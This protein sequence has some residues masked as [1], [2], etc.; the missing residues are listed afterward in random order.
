MSYGLALGH[1]APG[2]FGHTGDYD[3]YGCHGCQWAY[4]SSP[5]T[6]A[7]TSTS[8]V[9]AAASARDGKPPSS[10]PSAG[11]KDESSKGSCLSK[12]PGHGS[13][14]RPP[15]RDA[16][17]SA[18][19][20]APLEPRRFPVRAVASSSWAP[21]RGCSAR[22]RLTAPPSPRCPEAPTPPWMAEPPRPGSAPMSSP[23]F[24]SVTAFTTAAGRY[25][26]HPDVR[27]ADSPRRRS[28]QESHWA[29]LSARDAAGCQASSQCI[30]A[31]YKQHK[32]TLRNLRRCDDT[33][34]L[35]ALHAA[36][37]PRPRRVEFDLQ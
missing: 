6:T 30:E 21:R 15:W 20:P 12:T 11:R 2:G 22:S 25:S 28:R 32:A 10:A 17:A 26:P 29:P 1:P 8:E 16:L 7:R 35:G 4:D 36:A 19:P 5:P 27:W 34:R 24:D 23:D 14:K 3:Q 9:S 33:R 13:T 31:L 37:G 18:W